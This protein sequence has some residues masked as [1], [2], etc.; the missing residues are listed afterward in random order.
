M[1]TL[2]DRLTQSLADRYA[3]E[4]QVG[5][6][7]M[8]TVFLARDIRHDRRVAIK[9]LR[10]D[11]TQRMGVERFLREIRTTATLSHPHIVP[12]LD[13]GEADG[14]VYYVMPFVEGE[15]LRDR[16]DRE[17]Q[18]SVADA[19]RMACDI[20][21]ALDYAHRRGFVHRDV[22][23]ANILLHE[24]RALVADFGIALVFEGSGGV[25]LTESGTRV[26]TP[27]YMSPE[28]AMGEKHV[29]G[30]TDIFAVGTMLYEMLAGEPPFAGETAQAIVAKMMTTSPTSIRDI[31]PTVPAHV[32]A[33]ID[34]ALQKVAADRFGTAAE[35]AD[36][37]QRRD[38]DGTSAA[39]AHVRGSRRTAWLFAVGALVITG[40]VGAGVAIGRTF[41]GAR[42]TNGTVVR[43]VIPLAQDQLLFIAKDPLD[44]SRDGKYLAYVGDDSGKSQLFLRPL[45]DTIARAVP[46]TTGASTP[47][48]SPDGEW[49]AFFAD[50][51]L[52]KVPRSGGAPIDV[53]EMS[54]PEYGATWG[55]DGNLFYSVSD[56]ALR[57][58]RSDGT[59]A[60]AIVAEPKSPA[61]RHALGKLRWPAL[62]P[63]NERALV[64]TDSGIG[65]MD[66]ASGDVRIVVLRG[67]QARYLPTEQLLFDDD[68]GRV[69]V[70]G[71]DVKHGTVQG[72]STPVFEAFRGPGSG[73]TYFTVSDNGTLVYMPG[74]FQRSLVRVDRYGRETAIN[75]EPRG[76]RFPAVSPDGKSLAVT[77]D[78]RPSSIWLIDAT[79][80]Q[81]TPLTTDKLHS[82]VPLWSP[83]GTRIAFV[84]AEGPRGRIVWMLAQPGAELH[85]V[86]VPNSEER[87]GDI[88][89]HQWASVGGIFGYHVGPKGWQSHG[90]VVHFQIGDSTLTTLVSTPADDR[91]PA[92]SPD[93]KWLAYTSTISGANQVYVRPYPQTGP[94]VQVSSR[95]GTDP[96]WSRDGAE[97]FYRSG[98]SIM[99]VAHHPLSTSGVFGAPQV[100]FSGAYDFSQDRNWTVTPDGRFIMIKADPMMGRQLR[101]AFNW[102]DELRAASKAK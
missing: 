17:A 28:Q 87:L 42:A 38:G 60:I 80:G 86:L 39:V 9:V 100:L 79:T 48:F 23:P 46:G 26:G 21:S 45:D 98:S 31:R 41:T 2:G 50:N 90:D 24:N 83:D 70:V 92:L 33:A 74:S 29:T 94:S 10:E 25:R 81:G 71:F 47:F 43:T 69:R 52:K 11:V 64:S 34:G 44:I 88:G 99:S 76:Y 78:P 53:L 67:R 27:Q 85:Y 72:A 61:R 75:A 15:S 7:G 49:I 5:E 14:I 32:A 97:L 16:L 95:G 91:A 3:I 62:L 6:G 77:V 8:A 18:L 84:H 101:V 30:R 12:L 65:V 1:S 66:L 58:L 56:S 51:K 59:G 22:K 93:N 19:V 57:R 37:L 73:A 63:D 55:T 96:V 40:A 4:R 13:S 20:L 54:S 89:I 68:E 36:A 35:F 102:F 82:I